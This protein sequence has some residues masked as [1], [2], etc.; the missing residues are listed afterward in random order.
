MK[1]FETFIALRDAFPNLKIR[2]DP[3]AAWSVTTAVR[4]ARKLH[5][6]DVEYLEDPVWGMRAMSRVNA[7]SPW[8]TLASNM[9]GLRL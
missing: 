1:K 4:V 5:E 6:Y 8:V 9:S 2:L 7:K 3:N